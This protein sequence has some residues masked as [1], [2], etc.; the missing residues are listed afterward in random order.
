MPRP[1][2]GSFE[3][4]DM[5]KWGAQ[6]VGLE[7]DFVLLGHTHVQGLRTFGRFTVVNPGSVGLARDHRGKA[8]YAVYEEG[9][10]ESKQIPYAVGRTAA[11]SARRRSPIA[12][13]RAWSAS[14]ATRAKA[15]FLVLGRSHAG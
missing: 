1:K 10:M 8:C 7:A 13:S 2:A 3:Y 9:R 14:W 5:D 4:I 11:C 15:N 12:S 6:I